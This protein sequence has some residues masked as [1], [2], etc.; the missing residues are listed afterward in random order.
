ME[1]S[2]EEAAL[3]DGAVI[4]LKPASSLL[5]ARIVLAL[6][7]ALVVF[8]HALAVGFLVS[9]SASV[10]E[11]GDFVGVG[12]LCAA[13]SHKVAGVGIDKD[14]A[15]EFR[16]VRFVEASLEIALEFAVVSQLVDLNT[17]LGQLL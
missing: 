14:G 3:V 7:S 17:P 13:A 5:L 9:P 10:V 11:V 6:V 4:P 2:L 15:V 12:A 1:K 8:L 16:L